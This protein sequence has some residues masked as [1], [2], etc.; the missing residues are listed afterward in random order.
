MEALSALL[1]TENLLIYGVC[2]KC[3]LQLA[4]ALKRE[5]PE[6]LVSAVEVPKYGLCIRYSPLDV[7]DSKSLI[8]FMY[9]FK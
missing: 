9:L 4:E 2:A 3:C 7:S 1:F 5:V 8:T 6:F